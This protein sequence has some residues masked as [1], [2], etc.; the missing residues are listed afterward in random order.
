MEFPFVVKVPGDYLK[1]VAGDSLREDAARGDITTRMCIDPKAL[2]SAVFTV[3]DEGVIAGFEAARSVFAALDPKVRVG[4]EVEE[5][6]WCA[7]GTPVARVRG[8]A[9]SILSGERVALNFMQRLSG[10]ATMT[11]RF[12]EEVSGTG[13]R[14][15]DTRKTTPNLRLLE[16]Q[17]VVLGGGYSHRPSLADLVLIKDNHI[18]AAGGIAKAVELARAAGPRALVEVE[19]GPDDDL[20][21]LATV[22]ADILMFDNWPIENLR[23]AIRRARYFAHKPLIEVSGRIRLDNVRRIA[24][25]GPDFIS[26]GYITHSAPALDISLDLVP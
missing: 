15:L 2:A 23:Q 20:G 8:R 18:R 26:V 1:R 5:G 13:V 9:R 12:V 11:R 22:D 19:V 6:M 21:R 25:L 3:K 10:V 24:L 7:Q 17:A 16:K 4:F 14:I